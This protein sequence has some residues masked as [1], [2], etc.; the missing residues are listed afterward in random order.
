MTDPWGVAILPIVHTAGRVS[1]SKGFGD[2][3]GSLEIPWDVS[4]SLLSSILW[5]SAQ[6]ICLFVKSSLYLSGRILLC[7][8]V[9][10]KFR[11]YLYQS[12]SPI[13]L[14]VSC[15]T[16]EMSSGQRL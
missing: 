10:L 15:V 13:D 7:W 12:C 6:V 2:D 1:V 5:C 8:L 16:V 14:N 11:T 3:D 9:L 4:C